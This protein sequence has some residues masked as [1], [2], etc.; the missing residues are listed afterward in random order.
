VQS[1]AGLRGCRAGS[2]ASHDA[3][4]HPS[5]HFE[6][7]TGEQGRPTAGVCA[8]RP[9]VGLRLQVVVAAGAPHLFAAHEQHVLQ[10]VRQALQVRRVAE[11]PHAHRH[12]C[13][14]L[15]ENAWVLEQGLMRAGGLQ[16]GALHPQGSCRAQRAR[17]P[18]PCGCRQQRRP[19]RP[20]CRPRCHPHRCHCRLRSSWTRCRCPTPRRCH[21]CPPARCRLAWPGP[22]THRACNGGPAVDSRCCGWRG[23][24]Q[25]IRTL[26]LLAVIAACGALPRAAESGHPP[27]L[28]RCSRQAGRHLRI[29]DEQAVHAIGQG[30]QAVL[31]LV[32]RTL[33]DRAHRGP[34]T[35]GRIGH[36]YPRAEKG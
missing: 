6:P 27:H 7:R 23:P 5:R 18:A 13:R 21:R 14:R 11:G 34:Q 28:L 20:R 30:N 1:C 26:Q 19:G 33:N 2:A 3:P 8:G 16:Q 25:R 10:V 4:L 15:H 12:G 36:L 9:A 24:R 17:R 22:A 32:S 31:L 29:M 35:S